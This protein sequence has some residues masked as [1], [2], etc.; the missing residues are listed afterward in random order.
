MS[1]VSLWRWTC[2]SWCVVAAEQHQADLAGV[3]HAED[4]A[5]MHRGREVPSDRDYRVST[6]AAE[7]WETPEGTQ[8]FVAI[9]GLP[10]TALDAREFA[11]AILRACDVAEGHERVI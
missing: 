3:R 1:A 10:I 8:P 7:R 11:A 6:V 2:P 5:V 4:V 9:E